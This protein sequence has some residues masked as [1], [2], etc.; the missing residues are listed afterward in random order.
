MS[1]PPPRIVSRL[2]FILQAVG[3]QRVC[4]AAVKQFVDMRFDGPLERELQRSQI[5]HS[6]WK[7]SYC[8]ICGVEQ[9]KSAFAA[10]LH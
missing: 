1:V 2:S 3:L 8:C 6:V 4:Q 9:R 7:V 5:N 10:Q